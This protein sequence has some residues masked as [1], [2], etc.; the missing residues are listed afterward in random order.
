MT[1]KKTPAPRVRV[2][3]G[4]CV[5]VATIP[6]RCPLCQLVIPANTPHSCEN[7]KVPESR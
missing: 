5:L 4:S 1:K 3:Y 2:N 7:P 6:M